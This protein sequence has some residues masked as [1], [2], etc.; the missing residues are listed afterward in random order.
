MEYNISKIILKIITIT[1]GEKVSTRAY[2]QNLILSVRS[3]PN[4]GLKLSSPVTVAQASKGVGHYN[5]NDKV[6]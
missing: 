2:V 1:Q 4:H 5:G 6:V 3:G